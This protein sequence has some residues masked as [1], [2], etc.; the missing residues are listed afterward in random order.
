MTIEL[1]IRPYVTEKA[2]SMMTLNKYVFLHRGTANTIQV[3]QFLESKYDVEI[4]KVNIL[5]K[6]SKRVRR[7]KIVGLKSGFKKFIVTLKSDKNKDKI[8]SLF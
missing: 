7:G 4:K 8:E 5:K 6:T 3:Q 1:E 2:S